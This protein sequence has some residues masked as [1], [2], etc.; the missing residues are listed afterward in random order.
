[1]RKIIQISDEIFWGFN[2][3]IDLD[4]YNSFEELARLLKNQLII[5]LTSNNLLNQVDMAKKLELHNHKYKSYR[6]LY[7]SGEDIIYF[8]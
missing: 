7:E 8:W 2:M 3:T 5:F 1:M 6:N 4:N